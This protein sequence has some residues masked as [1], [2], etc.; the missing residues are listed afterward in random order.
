MRFVADLGDQQPDR[1]VTNFDNS[2]RS[3]IEYNWKI[4]YNSNEC[5]HTHAWMHAVNNACT[6]R[7]NDVRNVTSKFTD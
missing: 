4:L 2:T 7:C 3:K 6:R 5:V 1:D